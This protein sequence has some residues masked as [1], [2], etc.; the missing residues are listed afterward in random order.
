MIRRNGLLSV[1]IPSPQERKRLEDDEGDDE[2]DEGDDE[3]VV[4]AMNDIRLAN[5]SI[6]P[7]YDARESNR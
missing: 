7:G 6:T 2:D 3:D 4:R 5:I 1:D